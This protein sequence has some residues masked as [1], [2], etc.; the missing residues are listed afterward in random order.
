MSLKELKQRA[1]SEGVVGF[2]RMKKAELEA[3]LE[4]ALGVNLQKPKSFPAVRKVFPEKVAAVV[5]LSF[6]SLNSWFQGMKKKVNLNLKEKAREKLLKLNA[7]IKELLEKPEFEWEEKPGLGGSTFVVAGK[8][9]Y[10]AEGF[11]KNNFEKTVEILQKHFGFKVK[12]ILVCRMSSADLAEGTTIENDAFFSSPV[13]EVFEGTDLENLVKKMNEWMLEN[14]QNFQKGRSNWQFLRVEKL[15]IHLDEMTVGKFIPL[16]DWLDAKKALTNMKNEN[17]EKCFIYC[18][19]RWKY[20][21]KKNPQR[22]TPLLKKQCEEF[23]LDGISFPIS[24]RGIDR[25]E[26]QND[27]SVNVL[28]LDGKEIITLRKTREKKENHVILFKLKQGENEHFALVNNINRLWFGQDSK[29]KNQRQVCEGCLNSFN[30]KETLEVHQE[31]CVDDGVKA[32]LPPPRSVV[33]FRKVQCATIVPFVIY[34]DF[35][36]ILEKTSK[37]VGEK[38]TQIQHHIPCSFC[39]LPV[40]RVGE[41]FSPTFFRGKKEDDMG[42]IFLEMLVEEVKW[43]LTDIQEPLLKKNTKRIIWKEG[44]KE[45]FE[46]TDICWFCEEKIEEGKVADHCH[47]TGKF[48]GAA[49][50]L[51]NLQAR[52]PKFTPVFMHNLDGYD[53]HLFIKNAGNEF[54]EISAIANNEEKYVSFS[55]KIVWGEFED[56]EGKKHKLFHEI[57][58]LDSLKFMNYPLADL[59]KNLGKED[60]HCLKRFF[61]PEDAELLSRKGIYPY[62]FMDSFEKFDLKSLPE[63][64]EFFSQLNG[65]IS[66]EDFSHAKKV[67]EK[68]GIQNLGEYHDLYLKTDVFL[69]ADVVENFRTVLLKNYLLDPA[70]FLT[71]PSFFWAAML[72]M[73]KVKLELICEGDIEM[74]R[75]FERQIRG[76]VSTV[77]HRLSWANNKFMKD[78]D[79]EKKS[80]F[81][82][83]LDANSLY[84]TAMMQPLP[85]GGFEWLEERKLKNWEKIVDSEGW[86]CVLEVDLEYPEE[87]HDFH[88][89]FPLAP[90]LLEVG[91]IFKL[92][93]NLRDKE[94]MVLDGRNLKLYLSLGM[95][96][97]KIR[98]GIKFQEKAFM[99]PFIEWNTKLRT[100]AK[101]DFEKELF[102]LASNAVYGKTMENV[103]NRIN[104][105]LVNDRK[106]KA[107]LVKKINF[108]HATKFGEKIAAVHMRK[109]KVILDKPIFVGAGILD[110]SK[111]H[112]FKF[113]Y[114][115]VKEKWEKVQVLYSDTDSLIL[116][117]ETDDF[118][119][120]TA[121]DVE[122]WF[123]TS[124][125]PKDHFAENFPVGKNKKVLG[126]FKDE[127]DGKIIRGFVGLRAKCYSVLMEEKQQIKK[128]KGTKKNTVKRITHEDYVRVLGGEKFPL[129]KNVSFRSHLHEIFTEQM[130]KV[131]LSAEDDKRIVGEDGINTLAIGHWRVRERVK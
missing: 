31:F 83:Y 22:I 95:K 30:S 44:E 89:D 6:D 17:D 42:K 88:N 87:L 69:L 113:F 48:R 7:K 123:D 5:D 52:V 108:K 33:K 121:E 109:T 77:F 4:K 102:K 107:N 59:V 120:D 57:R 64:N 105:K 62:E 110:L 24:W 92:I 19:A 73:T 47:L 93:P 131:A 53:S 39:F 68:M 103:R 56:K 50:E 94:K 32:V 20:P 125:Y 35:E 41:E 37:L 27:I 9:G 115:Y 49:H 75:F 116:E 51:C 122:K 10:S 72:K 8:E 70:W 58:F 96:L 11:L 36:C 127:A 97:K 124:K 21:V 12:M 81:I 61:T 112:M 18:L 90:E 23:N 66:D 45:A 76:G 104:M 99:K 54:G 1:R 101:N 67:W 14:M 13:E 63:K 16:P 119:A 130:W 34:A 38:T 25:F 55:L 3:A 43:I 111:I 85:V 126:M 129:M 26:R 74:F 60:L 46:K 128:A 82:V 29:N 65:E 28:G 117:I 71:A 2:S 84:P 100:A 15:E 80:K 91:G 40:S 118:F 79:P 78:F 106:K 98:R 114:D 86:G